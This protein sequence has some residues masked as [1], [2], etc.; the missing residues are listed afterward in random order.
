MECRV[1]RKRRR[2]VKVDQLTFDRLRW[3][4]ERPGA[5]RPKVPGSGVSH[6]RREALA[7]RFPVHVTVRLKRGLASLRSGAP[8]HV[9]R[10]AFGKGCEKAGFRL[11][12]FSVLGNHLHMIVEAK[13]RQ[14]LSRGMQG[15][16]VRVARGLNKLW[17]RKGG[18]FADRYH[19]RI[20]RTPKQVRNALCYVLCNARKHGLHRTVH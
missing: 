9:L 4:G 20:L 12:H 11:V 1:V 10:M 13:D 8:Y 3:G 7:S 6:L 14:S 18:V 15:L 2:R 19:E 5:G 16:L 17:N